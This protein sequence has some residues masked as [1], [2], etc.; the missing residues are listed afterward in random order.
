[1]LNFILNTLIDMID[2]T[3]AVV[4]GGGVGSRLHPLTEHRSKP[5]V[6]IV[7]KYRL[8]DIPLSNCINSNI[9]KIFVLTMHNSASLNTHISESYRFDAFSKGFV[10][11]LAAEQTNENT[12]WYLGT[13]DAV[14]QNMSKYDR[15]DHDTILVLSGDQLYKMDLEELIKYHNEQDADVTVATIPVVEKDTT[16]FG[17]MKVNGEGVIND[18]VEKPPI[19]IVGKWKSELP[20]SFVSQGKN[21]LASMGIY[22]FKRSTMKKLFEEK[23][24]KNDFGKDFIPYTVNSDEYK[25]CSFMYDGY[26]ADIGTISSFM[27]ANLRLTGFLPEFHLYDNQ[28]KIYTHSRMLA[29][30]KYFGTKITHGLISGGV[31]CHAEEISRC[32]I[33]VRS[34]IGPRT[35]IRDSIVMG[36]NYYQSVDD[37]DQLPDN[38]LLGIGSDCMIQN[39]IFDKNVRI[40]NNVTIIGGPGLKDF[41]NDQYCIR[42][43]IIIVKRS[44][45]IESNSMIGLV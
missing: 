2:K 43:G 11:I 28:D 20:N 14:R 8:V 24:T 36:N 29:P 35:I 41:E 40:G 26:W 9:R 10:D 34:R 25:V 31:I 39:A 45:F 1:M 37:M 18:F 6:P 5:A 27:E 17:I 7:G 38:K 19:D 4:L 16:G 22:V 44:A 42:D 21:Y 30:S 13:A 33:G 32:I 12:D 15:I 3:I 23:K